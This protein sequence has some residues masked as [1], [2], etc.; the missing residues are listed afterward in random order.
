MSHELRTPMNAILGYTEM[1]LEEAEDQGSEEA[2]PD[3]QRILA[4]GRHLLAL[5]N[6]V[7]DLSKIEAGKM[8]LFIET[9]SVRE[10]VGDGAAPL[11]PLVE[12]TRNRLVIE[13][14]D[15]VGELT[16]D[17]TKVRQMLFNLLSNAAKFTE[18]GTVTLRASSYGTGAR[19]MLLAV[20]DTGI[21]MTP[22]QTARIFGEFTQADSSTTR[23]YGGTGL[24][25][26][27]SKKFCEMMGGEMT[28]E[29]EP[30]KGTTFLVDLP[31][32]VAETPVPPPARKPSTSRR[33]PTREARPRAAER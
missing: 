21:G 33:Q 23:K 5:I 16:A 8:T 18:D 28:V 26:S 24:G 10:L 11:A 15:D 20:S 7:L 9:F 32:V 27:I 13:V 29:S 14:D 4:A 22:E 2:V 12:K 31:V 1:L 25:L 30:G 6:D 3:L 19:R 17:E